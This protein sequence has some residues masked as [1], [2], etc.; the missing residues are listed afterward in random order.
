ML[1]NGLGRYEEARDA[2][3]EALQPDP[4]GYGSFL[5]PGAGRGRVAD[6]RP[7]LLESALGWLAERTG[8]IESDWALGI[9]ARV[10]ALM[11]EGEEAEEPL[12]RRRSSASPEPGSDPS[13]PALTSSTANGCDANAAASTR[14]SNCAPPSSASTAWA[15]EAFA[16]R[17][18]RELEATGEHARKRT[19]E[20]RR[21]AHPAGGPDRAP[22][23]DGLTNREIA[24]RLFISPEHRR[25]PP[26]QGIP[27]ARREVAHPARTR[28]ATRAEL[29]APPQPLPPFP[30]TLP[31]VHKLGSDPNL[32]TLPPPYYGV[33][34]CERLPVVATIGC[35]HTTCQ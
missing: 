17:A 32:C 29:G 6:R 28:P 26:P 35:I 19:V 30:S 24:A 12:P 5:V 10:R 9:A 33:R 21:P 3:W 13:S 20:T 15:R 14:E 1:Y 4:I 7:S 34:R 25:V 23:R 2:A 31:P 11:S 22:R 8:A 18:E 16:G 27:E